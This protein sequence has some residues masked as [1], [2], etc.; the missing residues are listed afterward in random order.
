MTN[1]DAIFDAAAALGRKISANRAAAQQATKDKRN[2]RR[3]ARYAT[4]KHMPQ[5]AKEAPTLPGDEWGSEED[6]EPFCTCYRSAPC[7]HCATSTDD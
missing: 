5:P 2:A 6:W 4:T 1:A 3:R 7:H